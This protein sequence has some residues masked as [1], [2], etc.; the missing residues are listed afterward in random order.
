MQ[1]Y[2]SDV[3][4]VSLQCLRWR[5]SIPARE[6]NFQNC[7]SLLFWISRLRL[8]PKRRFSKTAILNSSQKAAPHYG[9]LLQIPEKNRK[10]NPNKVEDFLRRHLVFDFSFVICQ[11]SVTF[12]RTSWDLERKTKR[13]NIVIYMSDCRFEECEN[14]C[15]INLGF[16]HFPVK[17]GINIIVTKLG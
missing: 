9:Y 8:K 15:A 16:E 1:D 3:T 2:H 10:C 11:K 13:M 17:H 14:R 5:A 6:P 4:V 7:S 12:F